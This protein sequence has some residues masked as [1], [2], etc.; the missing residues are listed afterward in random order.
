MIIKSKRTLSILISLAMISL[1]L[2]IYLA[3]NSN[4]FSV[5]AAVG[6]P[7]ITSATSTTLGPG[8]TFQFTATATSTSLPATETNLW[9]LSGQPG[10]VQVGNSSGLLS[11]DLTVAAGTYPFVV[12]VANSAGTDSQNFTL[13]VVSPPPSAG[14]SGSGG[15]ASAPVVYVYTVRFYAKGGS[16]VGSQYIIPGGKVKEPEDPVKKDFEFGGWY[17]DLKFETEYD[18]DLAVTSDLS[19]YAKWTDGEEDE[20]LPEADDVQTP[21]EDVS[22]SDWFAEAVI[23]V[24]GEGLMIGMGDGLFSPDISVSRAM[25]ATILYRLAGEPDV[26]DLPNPFGDVEEGQWY[27]D[28]VKWAAAETIVLGYDNG[29]FGPTDPVTKEQLAAL[30]YRTQQTNG[31]IPDD[32]LADREWPDWDEIET[33]AKNPVNVLTMQGLFRDIPGINFNPQTP[34]TRAEV[35]SILYRYLTSIE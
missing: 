23:Y 12:N 8:G 17:L 28:A 13:T 27:A 1:F 20:A 26:S 24:N 11:V 9:S 10:G 3:L 25:I 18:F 7:K 30:I 4:L 22:G 19:L 34:A 2:G 33:W 35:A 32:I 16:A 31:K 5:S 15:A 6:P 29:N 14:Y 21:F